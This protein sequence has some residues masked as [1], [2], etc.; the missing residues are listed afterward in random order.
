MAESTCNADTKANALFTSLTVGVAVPP[1]FD[2]TE[3]KYVFVPDPA[4][5]LYTDVSDLTIDDLTTV[6]LDGTGV[7]DK[8]MS[9]VDLHIQREYKKGRI[10]GDQY[11]EVY[12]GVMN[13]VLSNSVQFLL[14]KDQSKFN[15]IEAQMKARIAEINVVTA[16][17]NLD[18]AKI[19]ASKLVFDMNNSAAQYAL[20][21][22]NIANA[23][24][25]NCLIIAKTCVEQ[26][27]VNFLL[28]AELAIS[29][30]QRIKVLPSTVSINQVQ[31]DRLLPAQAALLEYDHRVIKP[32]DANLK[33]Y[34]LNSVLP[35][36]VGID[37]FQLNSLLPVTLAQEQYK[38]NTDMPVGTKIIKEQLEKE[39]AQ[40]ADT[41]TDG[42]TP[43]NGVIG[44]QRK[45]LLEQVEAERAKTLD[46]R[47]DGITPIVGSIGKQ[48]DLYTQQI[49]SF[50]K[51]SQHKTAKMYLDGW[52]TQ[53]TLDDALLAPTELQNTTVD[54][55]LEGVRLNNSL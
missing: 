4:S 32:I 43:I 25:E 37:E 8:L 1:T 34:E 35:A 14:T 36:K 52:I 10:T 44:T 53:K 55:V 38:L 15:A 31:A 45:L 42:T 28:P 23:N 29:E 51:D 41:R 50:I 5:P 12:M 33:S 46:T 22:I 11:A 6:A 3:A 39:R 30:Y 20:T 18:I 47:V 24:E 27:R 26:Y 49:D 40:T 7:F 16:T 54:T 48:K 19:E 21:K 2:F 13:G 9:S 17:V